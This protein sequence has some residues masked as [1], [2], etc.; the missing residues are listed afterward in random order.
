MPRWLLL[1]CA[2]WTAHAGAAAPE[3]SADAYFDRSR[4][5]LHCSGQSYERGASVVVFSS[6]QRVD[7]L[8]TLTAISTGE[9]TLRDA[10]GVKLKVTIAQLKQGRYAFRHASW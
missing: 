8:W 5:L 1:A 10:E 3:A 2:S 9:V 4:Q 7:D 6:G